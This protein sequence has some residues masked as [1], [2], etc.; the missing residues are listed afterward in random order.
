MSPHLLQS[1]YWSE[2]L[3]LLFVDG[4]GENIPNH[5]PMP[6][7]LSFSSYP[8]RNSAYLE[9]E[10]ELVFAE[11]LYWIAFYMHAVTYFSEQPH[12][13]GFSITFYC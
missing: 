13:V 9:W 5:F 8:L 2:N 11:W 4:L 1:P 12:K 6:V 7:F 3:E 10:T